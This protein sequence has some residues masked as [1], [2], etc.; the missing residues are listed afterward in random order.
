MSVLTK[1]RKNRYLIMI[2]NWFSLFCYVTKWFRSG[3]E[4]LF[5]V[6]S[7]L[8][9]IV[10]AVRLGFL[11]HSGQAFGNFDKAGIVFLAVTFVASIWNTVR[12]T[13]TP[14]CGYKPEDKFEIVNL[15]F[16]VRDNKSDGENFA[17]G[18]IVRLI[19]FPPD[20][21][22]YKGYVYY[23]ISDGTKINRMAYSESLE[24][25]L[26]KGKTITFDL[27]FFKKNKS[28]I[29]DDIH[30][31]NANIHRS[32][33]L[34]L[35][36]ESRKRS[37]QKENF[38]N[39]RKIA[40][41]SLKLTG[42]DSLECVASCGFTSYFTSALT[43]DI[44]SKSITFVPPRA[45]GPFEDFRKDYPA[46]FDRI[47]LGDANRKAWFIKPFEECDKISNHIGSVILAVTEDNYP[48]LCIQGK[49][50]RYYGGRLVASGS[51]SLEATDL[52][53]VKKFAGRGVF[54]FEDV[55]RFGMAREL[56]EE[57]GIIPQNW[58]RKKHFRKIWDYRSRIKI[59]SYYRDLSRS[60]LPIFVGFGKL[61]IDYA[62]LCKIPRKVETEII[63]GFTKKIRSASDMKEFLDGH[64][65]F[66]GE[67]VNKFSDQIML[68]GKLFERDAV[69]KSFEDVLTN[70]R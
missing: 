60:G 56:L 29:E 21:V 43:N 50:S 31:K 45:D 40:L 8:G 11:I 55:I 23:T 66:K 12:W 9:A 68:M 53:K 37:N 22:N 25:W 51:G 70:V 13:S 35:N 32:M 42:V 41:K 6:A 15:S 46:Y 59:I 48:V 24:A 58:L 65:R 14:G 67:V 44:F 34:A 63:T 19:D 7:I 61:D 28:K 20:G 39:S 33:W 69:R 36:I 47:N 4:K 64:I 49:N 57:T 30:A 52:H 54:V 2:T 17:S 10:G 18:Q 1:Y 62:K 26:C 16:A 38:F 27:E 3:S 5:F